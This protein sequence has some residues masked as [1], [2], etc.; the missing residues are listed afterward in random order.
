MVAMRHGLPQ[1]LPGW[2]GVWRVDSLSPNCHKNPISLKKS[3]FLKYVKEAKMQKKLCTCLVLFALIPGLLVMTACSREKVKPGP[4]VAEVSE[5]KSAEEKAR[6]EAEERK[7]LEQEAAERRWQADKIKFETEDIYFT[8][9]SYTLSVDAQEIL[10]RK[11]NWLHKSP[12][13]RVVIEGHT[14]EP[15]NKESNLAL[16]ERRAGAVKTFLLRQGIESSRLIPVSYGNERPADAGKTETSRS[17]NR[18]VHF[19]V[20][21]GM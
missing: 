19:V 10:I 16:G 6:K 9:G 20:E 14:D 15:G 21:R 2:C 8:K 17:K 7:R 12:E 13:V 11:A 3:W 4:A 5:D 1:T 18:R